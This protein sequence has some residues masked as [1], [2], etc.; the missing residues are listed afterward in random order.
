MLKACVSALFAVAVFA[1]SWAPASLHADIRVVT[2]IKPVHSLVAAVMNGVSAPDLLIEGTGSPH[3]YAMR[4]SQARNLQ[5]AN[6][7]FWVG[8]ELETFLIKP[9]KTAGQN[10][11]SVVLMQSNGMILRPFRE[12]HGHHDDKHEDEHKHDAE[13][14]HDDEHKH[15]AE[16]KHE[17]EH[18]HEQTKDAHHDH[19][20]HD[21]HG[22]DPHVWL[23]PE[24][25]KAMVLRITQAL[26]EADP[27]NA[28]TYQK[29]ATA[30]IV[31]LDQ[32]SVEISTTVNPLKDAK[33]VVFH[34]AYQYFEA[35][36][37]LASTGAITLNPDVLPGA[38]HLKEIKHTVA[39]LGVTCV[40]SEPQ[41]KPQLV[42]L[43][44]EGTA[45]K[46]SVLDP[47]GASIPAG[48]D[49]Y[50]ELMKAMALSMKGCLS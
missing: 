21:E 2:S 23:D 14:K 15:D 30:V 11:T 5:D 4:P 32:L 39:D 28:N 33:Y 8:P 49:Q 34:D 43:V 40:F 17:K 31:R 16:H 48:P 50:F 35:R 9:V 6:I 20:K 3:T 13:H 47:L 36:F 22:T 1:S 42:S 12:G 44:I 27:A 19:D 38:A 29:N 25:A 45:A 46:S 18:K 7:I 26:S 10:A 37:G 41:F 24:N